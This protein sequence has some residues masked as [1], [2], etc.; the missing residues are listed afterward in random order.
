MRRLLAAAAL[1]LAILAAAFPLNET[2][3][4]EARTLAR[5]MI[6]G[7][8]LLLFDTRD[9]TAFDALH[10][11]GA[12]LFTPADARDT[13]HVMRVFYGDGAVAAIG[14]LDRALRGDAFI[15]RGGVH[16]WLTDVMEPRLAVDATESERAAF[17]EA[18]GLSRFFGGTPV[19]DVPRAELHRTEA[20]LTE[21]VVRRGC[22]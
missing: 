6:Q 14:T 7:D 15:L 19:R 13:S 5:H 4:I 20:E 22:E 2:Q 16:A 8:E 17:E 21:D 12:R 11:P 3:W 9:R 1:L 18:A 10:L